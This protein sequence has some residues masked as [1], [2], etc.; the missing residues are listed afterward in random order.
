M[1]IKPDN[2]K[3]HKHQNQDQK[4]IQK[5]SREIK[6]NKQSCQT[7]NDQTSNSQNPKSKSKSKNDKDKSNSGN[8]V[9]HHEAS[10]A[11]QDRLPESDC[12]LV[13]FLMFWFVATFRFRFLHLIFQ[14][15]DFHMF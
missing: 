6:P 13:V 7:T 3:Q 5:T 10:R 12:F 2:S 15:F 4:Q 9:G 14:C 8:G 11:P 1:T